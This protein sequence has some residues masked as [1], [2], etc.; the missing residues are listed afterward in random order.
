M[1]QFYLRAEGIEL[2]WIGTG[3][4]IFSLNYPEADFARSENAW[5]RGRKMKEDGWWWH[6]ASLTD[7]SIRRQILREMIA[8][9]FA[10]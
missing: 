1:L 9:R 8:S 2:S 4:L 10:R 5:S 6:H 7:K 3:R